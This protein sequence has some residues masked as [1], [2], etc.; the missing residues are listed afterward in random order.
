M[1]KLT[2][3]AI[4]TQ[5]A[6]RLKEAKGDKTNLKNSVH[7]ENLVLF[8]CV[9][10]NDP[11]GKG[12]DGSILHLC[13]MYRPGK[14]YLYLSAD[15]LLN[16]DDP[17][18]IIKTAILSLP[19]SPLQEKDIHIL[20]RPEITEP[21]KFGIFYNDF[22]KIVSD[23]SEKHLVSYESLDVD[24]GTIPA[25]TTPL[26]LLNTS[27][28]TPAMKS[29][30]DELVILGN[31]DLIRVQVVSPQTEWPIKSITMEE[32]ETTILEN[33]DNSG[34][35]P[36]RTEIIENT[37]IL[38]LTH[39]QS[40]KE[41]LDEWDYSGA[42]SFAKKMRQFNNFSN[43]LMSALLLA[44]NRLKL[45]QKELEEKS[46][47]SSLDFS[48]FPIPEGVTA[49]STLD[50]TVKNTY[51]LVEYFLAMGIKL[52][53]REY[54]NYI[55]STTPFVD[56]LCK[57]LL[58]VLPAEEIDIKKYC[59]DDRL[60]RNKFLKGGPRGA[61]L[62]DVMTNGKDLPGKPFISVSYMIP[63]LKYYCPEY[64]EEWTFI[65]NVHKSV[66]NYAAH[67]L[68]QITP[69]SFRKSVFR[70]YPP[71]ARTQREEHYSVENYHKVLIRLMEKTGYDYG[72]DY[73]DSYKNMNKY[74]VSLL[75][76]GENQV[77]PGLNG[78]VELLR[79][80]SLE[81]KVYPALWI[82]RLVNAVLIENQVVSVPILVVCGVNPEGRREILAVEVLEEN[83][84]EEYETLL[85]FLLERGFQSP[86]LV[87]F[88]DDPLLFQAVSKT[89]PDSLF[90]RNKEKF[91]TNIAKEFPSPLRKEVKV[92]L[93]AIWK[94]PDEPTARQGLEEFIS[95][96]AT[97]HSDAIA[98]LKEGMEDALCFYLFSQN[99][100]GRLSSTGI[101]P[102]LNRM[103]RKDM[104]EKEIFKSRYLYES[105]VTSRLRTQ[106][107]L[108]SDTKPYISKKDMEKI[109]NP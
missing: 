102:Q 104:K 13:R 81:K 11:I 14:I 41:M 64:H 17:N 99:N 39:N 62:F 70:E 93:K 46:V 7:P 72:E 10:G 82:G 105:L 4:K 59:P 95:T 69:E 6:V 12:R 27:S 56:A 55:R 107:L 109:N 92:Q 66:R 31:P 73:L 103:I 85:N 61:E 53:R 23:I 57:Q 20:R 96:Y 45:N 42:Y 24:G 30:L 50:R 9:G 22:Q 35:C 98:Y 29:A 106:S 8:S 32:L 47:D 60:D 63:L 40:I 34:D 19:N 80:R 48:F 15:M 52:K 21:H 89:F 65:L 37:G 101:I 33:L 3:K 54:D 36:D 16:H 79:Q 18:S 67:S 75:E 68:K 5:N 77:I 44:S 86:N 90:Q 87:I 97:E 71:K 43:E 91:I 51:T 26:I 2:K 108:W 25:V 28:G 83:S 74:I 78:P 58:K 1:E 88:D 100:S 94:S 84:Q 76:R 49:P 38:S